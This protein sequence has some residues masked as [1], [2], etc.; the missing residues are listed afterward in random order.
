MIIA[1]MTCV[2]QTALAGPGVSLLEIGG[3]YINPEGVDGS[4]I[5]T[6]AYGIVVDE[7][8]DISIGLGYSNKTY[9]KLS[10]VADTSYA[11]GVIQKT[12]TKN[13]EYHTTLL[14]VMAHV[15][16]RIPFSPPL[17]WYAGGSASYTFLFNKERNYEEGIE[18]KRIYRGI[19]WILRAGMEYTIGSRSAIFAEAMYNIG[20]VKR[21][22]DETVK[23]LPI[24]D[25]V[26][27]RGFGLRAGLRLEFF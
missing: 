23:G 3:G 12:V 16:V 8:V 18:E 7:R 9:T 25:E 22:V 27:L 6:A 24:W 26:S 20:N 2:M 11:S 4:S 19:N 5:L 17:A 21:N 14:P 13:M 1:A 15:N 10:D